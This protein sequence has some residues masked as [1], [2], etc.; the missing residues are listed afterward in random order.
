VKLQPRTRL[1]LFAAITLCGVGVWIALSARSRS[2]AASPAGM[3]SHLPAGNSL[4]LF[5]DFDALERAGVLKLLSQSKVAEEPEYKAFVQATGFDYTRDLDLAALSFHNDGQFFIV[6]GRFDWKKLE[7]YAREHGGDCGGAGLCRMNGST[8]ERRISFFPLQ[9]NLMA[10]AV[11]PDSLAAARLGDL[12]RGAVQPLD[13][14]SDPVWMSVPPDV[15]KAGEKLPAGTRMFTTALAAADKIQLSL[16]PE[17]GQFAAR[18][19]VTCRTAQEAAALTVQLQH[20]TTLLRDMIARE[21][22]KPNPKDLSGVLTAGVFQQSG[23]RVL[24]QWP[25]ATG[26]LESLATGAE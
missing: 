14:P 5:V 20:A 23:R 11:S 3:L 17:R 26:F 6:K 15:L 4:V 10:L 12:Q 1:L 22:Q 7:Q 18:L 16:G 21:N 25:L 13:P 19:R 2:I 8:P 9:S 24:G